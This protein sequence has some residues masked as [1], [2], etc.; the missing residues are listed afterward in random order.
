MDKGYMTAVERANAA[1]AAR[2]TPR[3][4]EFGRLLDDARRRVERSP[5]MRKYKDI[6]L[7]DRHADNEG[8]LRWVL[9][10]N[11]AEIVEW[12]EQI[13]RDSAQDS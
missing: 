11:V 7:S 3:E 2:N 13:R 9:L 6:I 10:W 5:R 1:K 4:S 12:A 8:Y